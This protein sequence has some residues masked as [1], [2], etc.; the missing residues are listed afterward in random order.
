MEADNALKHIVVLERVSTGEADLDILDENGLDSTDSDHDA[1]DA[2][3]AGTPNAGANDPALDEEPPH[4]FDDDE[5]SLPDSDTVPASPKKELSDSDGDGGEDDDADGSGTSLYA[6][7]LRSSASVPDLT[8]AWLRRIQVDGPGAVAQVLSL[9]V[10]AARPSKSIMSLKAHKSKSKAISTASD[11]LRDEELILPHMIV[12]NDP[13]ASLRALCDAYLSDDPLD[14]S[15]TFLK[16]GRKPFASFWAS[17]ADNASDAVLYDTDCFDTLLSWLEA[18]SVASS[19]PLRH[20]ACVAAYAIVDGLIEVGG[21]VRTQLTTYQRQL[22]TERKKSTASPVSGWSR[23]ARGKGRGRGG[24]EFGV[25]SGLFSG[26][27]D[28]HGADNHQSGF[29][30]PV[31]ANLSVTGKGLATKIENLSANNTELDELADKVFTTIFVL[32]YRDVCADVRV[33]SVEAVS[34]W[35]IKYPEHF[36]DDTHNKYIG[37]LLFDKDAA[38]RRAALVALAAMFCQ[39]TFAS[40][41]DM[42]L[43]RFIKRVVEMTEDKDADV[44]VAAVR[45]ATALLPLDVLDSVAIDKLCSLTSS[46]SPELRRAAGALVAEVVKLGDDEIAG[47]A[48]GAAVV[49]A[50]GK[51]KNGLANRGMSFG[52][53]R[54]SRRKKANSIVTAAAAMSTHQAKEDI[55]D[56]IFTVLGDASSDESMPGLVLDAVWDHL[57]AVH[58]WDAYSELMLEHGTLQ[59]HKIKHSNRQSAKTLP[60]VEELGKDDMPTLALLLLSAA[61]HVAAN[62]ASARGSKGGRGKRRNAEEMSAGCKDEERDALTNCFAPILP[63]LIIQFR[64]DAR[65]LAVLSELPCL[66]DIRTYTLGG[67]EAHFKT[68]L[69]QLGDVL[70]RHTGSPNVVRAAA[71]TLKYLGS[72]GTA[73]AADAELALGKEAA[74]SAKA[75]HAVV[76]TG[77]DKAAVNSVTSALVRAAILA[78]LADLPESLVDDMLVLLRARLDGV[79]SVSSLPVGLNLCRLCAGVWLWSTLRLVNAVQPGRSISAKDADAVVTEFVNRRNESISVLLCIMQNSDESLRVRATALRAMCM[80]MTLSEGT[81]CNFETLCLDT[82]K[83]ASSKPDD[84]G[85]DGVTP[86]S[87]EL[88]DNKQRHGI[89]ASR[90]VLD[91]LV[92]HTDEDNLVETMATCVSELIASLLDEA[93]N[94]EVKVDVNDED[95]DVVSAEDT[96]DVLSAVGQVAF[97]H[98]DPDQLL[99]IPLLGLLLRQKCADP[100]TVAC[101]DM[102][103]FYHRRL[104]GTRSQSSMT[105]IEFHSLLQA[106][107]IDQVLKVDHTLPSVRA[108]TAAII[109]GYAF[110]AV[111]GANA[112]NL[113]GK[114]VTYGLSGGF[115]DAQSTLRRNIMISV[116]AVLVPRM[117]LVDA[118]DL[119]ETL[120]NHASVP[121]DESDLE[122]PEWIGFKNFRSC[123]EAV[124]TNAT[125]PGQKRAIQKQLSPRQATRG[126]KRA[127]SSAGFKGQVS[128]TGKP[129]GSGGMSHVRRSGRTQRVKYADL[130][131]DSDSQA[132]RNDEDSE[133]DSDEEHDEAVRD[134]EGEIRIEDAQGSNGIQPASCWQRDTAVEMKARSDEGGENDCV[135]AKDEVDESDQVQAESPGEGRIMNVHDDGDEMQAD[136]FDSRPSHVSKKRIQGGANDRRSPRSAVKRRPVWNRT[137]SSSSPIAPSHNKLPEPKPKSSATGSGSRKPSLISLQVGKQSDGIGSPRISAVIKPVEPATSSRVRRSKRGRRW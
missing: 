132:D 94:S 62:Q 110:S 68:L 81:R 97:R 61:K 115:S 116:G 47:S 6:A 11:E 121:K 38:V 36:L 56:L 91:S 60:D 80:I 131:S 96:R 4:R 5:D 2:S 71:R 122:T 126:K 130:M 15:K 136:D 16:R 79:A 1:P 89:L 135:E 14:R 93:D 58:C 57:P 50:K 127:R 114:V 90:K 3:S 51:K 106:A 39:P 55:R 102:A 48:H 120:Q 34:G 129:L 31:E 137:R 25:G 12:A 40:S 119:L 108:L 74:S 21:R 104:H 67:L 70:V 101:I 28:T 44:C 18:M 128:R 29:R 9:V 65:V 66:F 59:E 87:D 45:L 46:E 23:G 105:T 134:H 30:A 124:S 82:D 84:D 41:L 17:L 63:K 76:R 24:A 53:V 33:T 7:M 92:V 107:K 85:T 123:I 78:D 112:S 111:Q 35:I 95:A 109:R 49:T 125:L 83:N 22:V 8:D 99:H 10:A 88:Q 100:S 133:E 54:G 27:N 26:V 118:A 117:P 64:T 42:F 20:A 32:K 43:R 19:R 13:P 69:T 77:V 75:I 98:S 72:D 86:E 103:K 52:A 113:L 73:L 37:W